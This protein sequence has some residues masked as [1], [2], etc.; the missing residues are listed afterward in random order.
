MLRKIQDSYDTLPSRNTSILE[1]KDQGKKVLGYT[2]SIFPEE[3]VAAA[4]LL[5]IRLMGTTENVKEGYRRI[6]PSIC[7]FGR[8][9][10]DL[11][12]NGGYSVFDGV[13]ISNTCDIGSEIYMK[14][15]RH[16]GPRFDYL[17]FIP[18][19]NISGTDAAHNFFKKEL[20]YFR[21]SLEELTGTRIS[22]EA[23]A[24][25]IEV[26][27]KNRML[28]QE[29]YELRGN[30]HP[31]LSGREVAEI[32]VSNT[33]MPKE[34]SN[35]LISD[36]IEKARD[37]IDSP[38][39]SGPR[40]HL[41]GSILSDFEMFDL[42]EECGG[43]VVSDDLCTGSRYFRDSVDTAPGPMDALTH[44]YLD[45]I[46]CPTMHTEG[47]VQER[48]NFI[49]NMVKR[50]RADGVVFCIQKFCDTHLLDQQLLMEGLKEENIPFIHQEVEQGVGAARM[51]TKLEAFFEMIGGMQDE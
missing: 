2:C 23:L 25:T 33:Q 35:T 13:V 47:K 4:G 50:Y 11:A 30:D 39:N 43:M 45:G 27:N 18:R 31:K 6:S 26:Y 16:A 32:L 3:L 17:Y 24:D 46:P 8:S 1:W 36:V 28:L 40:L 7:Y 14:M 42:I 19:P 10:L 21:S 37:R 49:K 34:K 48:L 5:P 15:E 20:E 38:K 41:C 12:L 22:D 29:I 9:I 51:R 44:R